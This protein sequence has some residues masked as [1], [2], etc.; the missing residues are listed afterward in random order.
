MMEAMGAL[1]DGRFADVERLAIEIMGVVDAASTS[2]INAT[3]QI[4]AA[5]YWRGRDEELLGSIAAFATEQLPQRYLLDLVR[6]SRWP[7][8][9]A[10][11]GLRRAR[12]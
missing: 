6:A 10:R 4:A 11:S 3:V 2:F 12:R 1:L 9:R 7:A 8:R 5:W